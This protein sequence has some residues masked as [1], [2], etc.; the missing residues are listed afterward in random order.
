MMDTSIAYEQ[1]ALSRHEP[2][3]HNLVL[4]IPHKEAGWLLNMLTNASFH[5]PWPSDEEELA[6]SEE[7][8]KEVDSMVKLMDSLVQT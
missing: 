8:H 7:F 5:G 4:R 1:A 2:V 3:T 6:W